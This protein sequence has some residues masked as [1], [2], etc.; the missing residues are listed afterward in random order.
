M[1]LV[2]SDKTFRVRS[3]RVLTVTP[4]HGLRKEEDPQKV[5]D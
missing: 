1:G 3:V 5:L 2:M 4:P